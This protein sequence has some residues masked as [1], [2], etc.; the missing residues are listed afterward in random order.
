MLCYLVL[1]SALLY[2]TLLYSLTLKPMKWYIPQLRCGHGEFTCCQRDHKIE[3]PD[4]SRKGQT[5]IVS[6]PCDKAKVGAT[7]QSL[8][9]AKLSLLKAHLDRVDAGKV[10]ETED[11][12]VILRQ[13]RF[14]LAISSVFFVSAIVAQMLIRTPCN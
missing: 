13:Y 3:V 12:R 6:I 9:S 14:L 11:H 2:S 8:I 7:L 4:E 1:C 5:K 10:K